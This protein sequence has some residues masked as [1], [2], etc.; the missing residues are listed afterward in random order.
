LADAVDEARSKASEVLFGTVLWSLKLAAWRP[1]FSRTPAGIARNADCRQWGDTR[2]SLA[3]RTR[4]VAP[5]AR[6]LELVQRSGANRF[7]SQSI[8]AA[9]AEVVRVALS[10]GD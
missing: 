2:R 7:T 9:D 8:N 5:G 4:S 6:H 10:P 3:Q 1:P